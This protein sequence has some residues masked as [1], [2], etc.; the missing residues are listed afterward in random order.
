MKSKTA[1][2]PVLTNRWSFQRESPI[3][4]KIE[5]KISTDRSKRILYYFET[6]TNWWCGIWCGSEWENSLF[7]DL[8]M[9]VLCMYIPFQFMS[10]SDTMKTKNGQKSTICFHFFIV[11]YYGWKHEELIRDQSVHVCVTSVTVRTSSNDPS[12]HHVPNLNCV[13][14]GRASKHESADT[15]TFLKVTLS[16]SC[17][18]AKLAC[19]NRNWTTKL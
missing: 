9:Y 16:T 13:R 12:C 11:L 3:H 6:K 14:F 10:H 15:S 8:C 19:G 5:E 7:I 4:L 17:L 18:S 1:S 2:H